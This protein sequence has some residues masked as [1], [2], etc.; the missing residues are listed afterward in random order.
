MD[1]QSVRS[2]P[3]RNDLCRRETADGRKRIRQQKEKVLLKVGLSLFV[4]SG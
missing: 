4:N 2:A 1:I 3:H